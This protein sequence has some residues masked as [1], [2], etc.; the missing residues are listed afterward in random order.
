MQPKKIDRSKK[1]R[2]IFLLWLTT[3]ATTYIHKSGQDPVPDDNPKTD[4]LTWNHRY[5]DMKRSQKESRGSH[6]GSI[7]HLQL[8][9]LWASAKGP[10]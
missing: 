5:G 1:T 7:A 10:N 3:K 2:E 9:L 6:L 4:K 8:S